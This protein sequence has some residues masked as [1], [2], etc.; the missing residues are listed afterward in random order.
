M[1]RTL[2]NIVSPLIIGLAMLAGAYYA[3][4]GNTPPVGPDLVAANP[5]A[6]VAAPESMR[7][8]IKIDSGDLLDI[9]VFDSPE[10]AQRVRVSRDGNVELSLLGAVHV[11][12]MTPVQAQHDIENR[13]RT[14]HFVKDPHVSVFVQEYSSQ[15]IS[16]TGQVLH[17]GVYPSV[18]S[19]SLYDVISMAGG[20]TTLAGRSAVVVRR[21]NGGEP[22]VVKFTDKLADATT[23]VEI[24]PGDKVEIAR[25]P[26]IY[27]LGEVMRPGGFSP[28]GK[29]SLTVLQAISMAQGTTRYAKMSG[30][31]VLHKT[32]TGWEEHPLPLKPILSGE[33][34]DQM[35]Q[36][37]DIVYIP[38]SGA[39]RFADR[40]LGVVMQ[41]GSGMTVYN[42][43]P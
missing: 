18:A 27:V 28:E 30:A 36:D 21:E 25:A 34:Q 9:S 35:L 3:F 2:M 40:A 31:R 26:V 29:E 11:A 33:K 23:G 20:L 15:G 42:V 6:S 43:H 13:L 24:Y 19:R 12:G 32:A 41:T 37:N 16:V 7:S 1:N 22:T 5:A 14:G 39:K 17:P 38:G 4:A 10:L 8:T